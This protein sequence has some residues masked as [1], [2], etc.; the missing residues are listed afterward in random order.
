MNTG[1]G[2]VKS[3]TVAFQVINGNIRKNKLLRNSR[4]KSLKIDVFLSGYSL[5]ASENMS[6]KRKTRFESLYLTDYQRAVSQSS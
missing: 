4:D 6:K 5:I 3:M 1:V 2:H